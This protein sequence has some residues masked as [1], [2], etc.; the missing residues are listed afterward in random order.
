MCSIKNVISLA[1]F[2]ELLDDIRGAKYSLLIDESTDVSVTK[3]LCLCV[4]YFSRKEQTV[5][6]SFLGLIPVVSTTGQSLFDAISNFLKEYNIDI[7]DCIGLGTDGANNV[8][9]EAN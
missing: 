6:T 8:S 1:L 5:Q 9:G 7:H 4:K 2:E 3:H